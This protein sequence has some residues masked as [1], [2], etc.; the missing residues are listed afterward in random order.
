MGR[1][2]LFLVEGQG[3][4]G[5]GCRDQAKEDRVNKAIHRA[6]RMAGAA[7]AATLLAGCGLSSIGGSQ[8]APATGPPVTITKHIAPS[9]LMAVV[10]RRAFGAALSGLV[11][12]TARPN[13]DVRILD[14]GARATTIVASDS[15]A[16]SRI[17]MPGAPVA[18]DSGQT[19]YLTAQYRKR[20]KD[21]QTRHAAKVQ[22]EAAQTRRTVSAWV[23]GLGL[24]QKVSR[25]ADAPGGTGTLAAA[26]A[27]AAT[28][29]AS[30][31]EETENV[32]GP[33]RVL[34]L[35]CDKLSGSLPAGE[36]T[37]DDVIVITS[38]LPT[39]AASAAQ[40]DLLRAGAA[41]AAVVGPEV[42]SAQLDELVSSDLSQ[43]A[44]S[45]SVSAPVLFGNDSY[46]LEPTAIRV[47]RKL[48]PKLRAPGVTVV[49]NGYA[50]V[51]GTA[52]ANYTLSFQRATAV[53]RFLE[54]SGIPES[55]LIIVGHGAS[56]VVGSGASGANRRVLVVIEKPP[57][58]G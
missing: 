44:R 5:G 10:T 32:F 49:I 51:P 22:A 35:F 48:L 12:G 16:P 30:L 40:A 7:G 36:L 6:G 45:D 52:E 54:A 31:E 38:H 23:S 47:L 37:G 55:S 26:S 8:G 33:R 4:Y 1:T 57:G 17:V 28:A 13:E 39:A 18:P 41:Q 3:S 46:A 34:V 15:P 2:E 20:L 43:G 11:T 25:L 56:D 53:A 27:I 14:A 24:P 58:K 9:V 21:W 29:L 50:S 42:T 19:D